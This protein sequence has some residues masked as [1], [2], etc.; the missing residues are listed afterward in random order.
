MKAFVTYQSEYAK[1]YYGKNYLEM[2][3]QHELP[4][5]S[6]EFLKLVEPLGRFSIEFY[7]GDLYIHFEDD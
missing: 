1:K 2:G 7:K 4:D 5:D 3:I 6:M